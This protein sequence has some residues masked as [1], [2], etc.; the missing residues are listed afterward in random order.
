MKHRFL[1][2]PHGVTSQ[3]T[4]SFIVTAVKTSSLTQFSIVLRLTLATVPTAV[5]H[6]QMGAFKVVLRP[7]VF[8]MIIIL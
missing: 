1:R 3:K 6:M 8:H 7:A 4:P 5:A 2:E